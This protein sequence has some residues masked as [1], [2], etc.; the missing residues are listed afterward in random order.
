[1][2]QLI[3]ATE[4]YKS[5]VSCL[6]RI[7]RLQWD[8]EAEESVD[9]ISDRTI[10][11]AEKTLY[12]IREEFKK[13]KPTFPQEVSCQHLEE[14]LNRFEKK[15]VSLKPSGTTVN[16]QL[17]KK[18]AVFAPSPT[19][20]LA[21]PEVKA[22]LDQPAKIYKPLSFSIAEAS[23]GSQKLSNLQILD[24]ISYLFR[25]E[26]EQQAL[27]EFGHLPRPI[28][29]AI[30]QALSDVKGIPLVQAEA[31]FKSQ[32]G[33]KCYSTPQE[34]ACA[35]ELAK[36]HAALIEII[37]AFRRKDSDSAYK[38]FKNLPSQIKNEIF[39]KHWKEMGSPV[40][41]NPIAHHDFGQVSFLGMEE[42]CDVPPER[43]I[44]TIQAY[45]PDYMKNIHS[46]QSIIKLNQ[47]NWVK[48]DQSPLGG[49]QK[50]EIKKDNLHKMASTI[51][52]LFEAVK[53]VDKPTPKATE[54][55]GAPGD[56]F[57]AWAEAYVK[58]YPSLRPFFFQMIPNLILSN[59]KPSQVI[60]PHL[61]TLGDVGRKKYLTHIMMETLATLRDG[62]YINSK[63]QKITLDLQPAINSVYCLA[64]SGGIKKRDGNYKTQFFLDKK[65]CLTVT[66]ECIERGLRPIVLD[67][68]SDD[69]FGGGY[70]TGAGAQEEN[71][72]RRSGLSIAVDPKQKRQ[73]QDFYPLTKQGNQAGLYVSNVPVFRGEEGEGYPYLDK[74]F[75]TAVAVMAA[76]NF[77]EEHQKQL[78][79]SIKKLIADEKTGELRIP[80][81]EAI[82]MKGKLRN[83]LHMAQAHDSIV[84]MPLGCGAFCN[85]P[86]H[87]SEMIIE[88]ITEEF[89]HS[90]KEIH[91]AVLDDHN[92]GKPHNPRGN[93]IEFKET[94]ETKYQAIWGIGGEYK[95]T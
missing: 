11:C 17:F 49:H 90:F 43:K 6:E 78:G 83:V 10:G 15:L 94:I 34:K 71:I 2:T 32:P 73:T 88:L 16:D 67:A 9:K 26:K 80:P 54:T 69:H 66:R 85:P 24:R 87:V 25:H 84:L 37:E 68:A 81:A 52:P 56:S 48:I 46:V 36:T 45:F 27:A 92:T 42:R 39:G 58:S 72:C 5:V 8:L 14:K 57:E 41:P 18:S 1:M 63:G 40:D 61:P 35:V 89:P 76:F 62:H 64:D 4:A 55:T 65:D 86:K 3:S 21:S 30:W 95:F 22:K 93:Y 70:M 82:E 51:V 7:D 29:E 28:Q 12:N 19:K 59:E 13:C 75:E 44:R 31:A 60:P 38:I 91:I 47:A 53:S 33:E 23:Q 50:N 74:P 79:Q 77:N 20:G